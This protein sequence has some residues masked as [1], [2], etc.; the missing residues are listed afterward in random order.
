MAHT[1]PLTY[2]LYRD[3]SEYL[4]Q[5]ITMFTC[6]SKPGEQ[7]GGKENNQN[8][9]NMKASKL[10]ENPLGIEWTSLITFCD[11]FMGTGL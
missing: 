7:K 1:E 6:V 3:Y 5:V 10:M 9:P 11:T 2:F 8:Q 4:K